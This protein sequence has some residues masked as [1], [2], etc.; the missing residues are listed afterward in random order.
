MPL[1]DANCTMTDY[2]SY[3]IG[4]K[5]SSKKQGK[6]MRDIKKRIQKRTVKKETHHRK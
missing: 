3:C 6:A 5:K 2:C 4:T 1:S